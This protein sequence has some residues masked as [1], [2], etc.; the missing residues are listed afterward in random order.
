MRCFFIFL[1]T[2]AAT[3][4]VVV[5]IEQQPYDLLPA[6][7]RKMVIHAVEWMANNPSLWEGDEFHDRTGAFFGKPWAHASLAYNLEEAQQPY[8]GWLVRSDIDLVG[9]DAKETVWWWIPPDTGEFNYLKLDVLVYSSSGVFL[10]PAPPQVLFSQKKGDGATGALHMTRS[11][12]YVNMAAA[13]E[14]EVSGDG[15]ILRS[16]DARE[17][18]PESTELTAQAPVLVRKR[19]YSRTGGC[20][21]SETT[22]APN[23][24]QYEEIREHLREG[25]H[26]PPA[27][28]TL[29][30]HH[31][32]PLVHV[33][34]ERELV[35]Q[36]GAFPVQTLITE[37]SSAH[38]ELLE[39]TRQYTSKQIMEQ[40]K[41]N[42]GVGAHP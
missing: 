4:D 42:E 9:D 24:D 30:V 20:Q 28:M 32:A 1:T 18:Y 41:K 38:P 22:V 34:T 7:V 19:V 21:W 35:W 31:I 3:Q 15:V 8:G 17:E 37:W 40:L 23:S 5:S 16:Y 6:E 27:P 26:E 14:W 36:S 11:S 10:F 29:G 25:D 13:V 39:R 2:I 33:V 12:R